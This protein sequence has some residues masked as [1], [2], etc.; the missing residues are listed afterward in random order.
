MSPLPLHIG[1]CLLQEIKFGLSK[2]WLLPLA[3]VLPLNLLCS[4]KAGDTLRRL[5]VLYWPN[6]KPSTQLTDQKSRM[7][8]THVLLLFPYIF[9]W[10]KWHKSQCFGDEILSRFLCPLSFPEEPFYFSSKE[11]IYYVANMNLLRPVP[12][13]LA[14]ESTR[15]LKLFSSS[16]SVIKLFFLKL[17]APLET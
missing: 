9:Q 5:D 16:V 8:L 13:W 17:L 14:S 11:T 3:W 10:I 1:H 7:L 6:G 4:N 15:E 2:F 12:L